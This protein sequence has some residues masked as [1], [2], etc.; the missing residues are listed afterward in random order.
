VPPLVTALSATRGPAGMAVTITGA[1]LVKATGVT[2]GG[3]AA[4][5]SRTQSNGVT[6]IVATA[7]VRSGG[8]IDVSVVN[9]TGT[10]PT[11]G[12][13]DDFTYQQPAPVLSA[14][15]PTSTS[16]DGGG[17]ITVTGTD[18]TGASA[19]KVGT[20]MV[21]PNTVSD[22]S[23]TFTAPAHITGSVPVSV[24]TPGGTTGN[25]Y[26][27]YVA[28][29]VPTLTS[30]SPSTGATTATTTVVVTGTNL[31]SV[32]LGTTALSYTPLSSTTIRV[33][34]KPR[35]AGAA[36]LKIVTAGGSSNTL[37][38]TAVAPVRPSIGT[39]SPAV[40]LTTAATVVTVNGIGF[41][42]ATRLSL[43]GRAMSFT[44]VSATQ[45]RFTRS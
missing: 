30:L 9:P 6:R 21:T 10:S 40:G 45:L 33:F 14:I 20:D 11:D 7:P 15:N 39:L 22:T 2:F 12:T 26:L 37:V 4:A 41:S 36:A 34:V 29:S 44:R 18:L 17:T 38:F 5:F 35:A 1:G 27:L 24:T 16:Q 19:V 32:T 42:G 13:A 43:G 25:R 3:T 8:V 23:L 28:A 31:R